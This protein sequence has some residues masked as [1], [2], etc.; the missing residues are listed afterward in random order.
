MGTHHF[1]KLPIENPLVQAIHTAVKGRARYKVNGLYRSEALKRYLE[2]KLSEKTGIQQVRANHYTGN[3]LVLFPSNFSQN[4]IATLIQDTVLDYRQQNRKSSVRTSYI[5]TAQEAKNFPVNQGKVNEFAANGQQKTAVV[6]APQNKTDASEIQ[7]I[8]GAA[9]L[10]EMPVQQPIDKTGRQLILVSGTAVGTLI[11]CTTLL[12]RYGLDESILLAIQKLHAPLLDRI[13]IGITS[14]GGSVGLLLICLA[15][16]TGPLYYKRPSEATTFGIAT[17]GAIGLNYLLKERFGRARPALWDRIVHVGHYSF[18]SG[19]AMMSMVIYGF[20]GYT[21]AKQFPQHRGKIFAATILLIAA[22][23]FSRLYLG[24]HWPTDVV[25][26]YAVGLLW[27]IACI[28][29]VNLWKQY[30]L[31][32]RRLQ[33]AVV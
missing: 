2:L 27:L 18:P 31:P 10:T 28:L 32:E 26:G 25:A 14:L 6:V 1:N 3:V 19:H 9:V 33:L 11:V 15:L 16:G 4:A 30:C 12:H 8:A 5:S 24:V 7:D 23:G 29:G 20:L 17:I 13:M 22:I 21:L